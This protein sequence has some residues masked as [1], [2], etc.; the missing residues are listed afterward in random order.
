MPQGNVLGSQSFNN[1]TMETA[2]QLQHSA[3]IRRMMYAPD[4]LVVGWLQ[5]RGCLGASWIFS[6]VLQ[7]S[8]C[9]SIKRLAE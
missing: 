4:T 6:P 7:E 5:V 1:H 2:Q 9:K 8:A 3:N